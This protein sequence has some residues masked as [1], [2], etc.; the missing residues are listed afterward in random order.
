MRT[1]A[2]T[3]GGTRCLRPSCFPHGSAH[4]RLRA[5]LWLSAAAGRATW[6]GGRRQFDDGDAVEPVYYV[7]IIPMVLVNGAHGIGTG[8]AARRQ[9][10]CACSGAFV[11]FVFAPPPS[12]EGGWVQLRGF[13]RREVIIQRCEAC[14][15]LEFLEICRSHSATWPTMA[16][17]PSP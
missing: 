4:R 1:R 13:W 12:P 17:T 3:R 15:N 10:L 8:C 14:C 6:H 5:A 9:A 11:R 7:P 16:R 2:R